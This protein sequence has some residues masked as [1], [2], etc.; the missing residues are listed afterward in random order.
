MQFIDTIN[1]CPGISELIGLGAEIY[2]V[3]GIVRD[4]FLDLHSNL[5][6]NLQ[7]EGMYVRSDIHRQLDIESNDIDI[8]VRLL[9]LDDIISILK[10]YGSINMVGSS[11]RVLKYIPHGY[12]YINQPINITISRKDFM[13]NKEE[14]HKGIK[15]Y[16]D[17]NIT[18]L[19]DLGR[20]DFTINAMALTL[21]GQLIDPFNGLQDLRDKIIRIV[22]PSSFIENSLRILRGIRFTSRFNFKIDKDSWE[23]IINNY[24]TIGTLSGERIIKE[25]IVRLFPTETAC[26][27][28]VG[29][30]WDISFRSATGG[31]ERRAR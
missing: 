24:Q 22:S 3:G 8:I 23:L 11:F 7:T 2:L 31:S 5:H 29:N 25:L 1:K 16:H 21:D 28:S 18:L 13:D 26:S 19:S 14:R 27:D 30:N 17:Q 4:S 12:N 20:R 9:S 15:T 10:N 6:S